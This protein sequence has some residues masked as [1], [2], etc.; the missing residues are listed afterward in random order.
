MHAEEKFIIVAST[1]MICV[2]VVTG[3]LVNATM[4]ERTHH[5][6]VRD[7]W[8]YSQSPLLQTSACPPCCPCVP[9]WG[10]CPEKQ[11]S[12][13]DESSRCVADA[14]PVCPCPLPLVWGADPGGGDCPAA[15]GVCRA[16]WAPP[17]SWT[18]PPPPPRPP[19]PP[20]PPPPPVSG[21]EKA[22][23]PHP[24]RRKGDTYQQPHRGGNPFWFKGTLR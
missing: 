23:A 2:S 8:K 11:W 14:P 10:T 24:P 17:S 4:P 13:G 3:F 21:G 18:P 5:M 12:C 9:H 19:P 16:S 1:M 7:W 6:F 15:P 22:G 20:P